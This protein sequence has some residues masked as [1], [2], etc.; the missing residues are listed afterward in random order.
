MNPLLFTPITLGEITLKN[1]IIMAPMCQYSSVQ[2]MVSSW[3]YSHY[4]SRAIGGAA[5]VILEATA[6]E[7]RGRISPEDLGIWSDD[8]VHGLSAL[9]QQIEEAGSLPGIQLAHAGRKAGTARPFEGYGPLSNETGGWPIIAPDDRPYSP[10]HR[11]PASMSDDD[12]QEVQT[13]FILAARRAVR[14]G[15]KLIEIHAAHGYLIHSFLSPLSNSRADGYGGDVDGRMRFLLELAS[16][17][18]TVVQDQAIL[19][20]RISATD[21]LENGWSLADSILL[22]RRL[23]ET[24]VDFIHVSSGGILPGS[25]PKTTAP[26]YQVDMAAEIRRNSD[27]HCAAVGLITQADQAEHILQHGQADI[28][29]LGRALLREPYWP[30]H[31]AEQLGAEN[32]CPVQYAR[33]WK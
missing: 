29:S 2:G 15:Y 32:P 21:W 24:G 23:K 6:V 16:E 4:V 1:R 11:K 19:S 30:Q 14:A 9:A 20:V 17:L 27:I 10:N 8:H 25:S 28:I 26:G 5:A 7:P 22:S 18:K 13:A 3:H 31:A 33:A 12:I